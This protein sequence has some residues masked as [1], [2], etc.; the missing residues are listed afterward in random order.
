[1]SSNPIQG[2]HA[3]RCAFNPTEHLFA[4]AWQDRTKFP[5]I[6]IAS[7][8][9]G[10]KLTREDRVIA[11]TVIQWLGSPVGREFLIDVVALGTSPATLWKKRE[12]PRSSE[13]V[14]DWIL[15]DGSKPKVATK[16]QRLVVARVMEW[17]GADDGMRWLS[18][19]KQG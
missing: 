7:I 15:G 18:R 13:H 19:V 11:A 3:Q 8:V 2:L 9:G 4:S 17:L 12:M 5:R 14:L 10:H 6:A 1:V 16:R